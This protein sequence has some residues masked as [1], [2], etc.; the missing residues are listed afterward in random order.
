MGAD[1]LGAHV[2]EAEALSSP[3]AEAPLAARRLGLYG[4][5]ETAGFQSC[6]PGPATPLPKPASRSWVAAATGV[7][8]CAVSYKPREL[9]GARIVRGRGD[10]FGENTA[11]RTSSPPRLASAAVT[12]RRPG[13]PEPRTRIYS[14]AAPRPE[15]RG[16][17]V[18]PVAASPLALQVLLAYFTIITSL[19][20]LSPN[21]VA[22]R[23]TKG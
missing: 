23:G 1:N 9:G 2:A 16:Q 10:L 18:G 4:R 12:E 14:L 17:G 11:Y 19:K 15:G 22:F 20:T 8:G 5:R 6:F 21:T 13:R 3:L 7:A